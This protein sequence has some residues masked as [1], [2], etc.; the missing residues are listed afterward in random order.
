[1]H[2][3]ATAVY[4]TKTEG[5]GK[6]GIFASR[7]PDARWGTGQGFS[8]GTPS[9]SLICAACRAVAVPSNASFLT[10]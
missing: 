1:M 7:N 2:S 3:M 9:E 5:L 10:P 6:A 4:L 8:S